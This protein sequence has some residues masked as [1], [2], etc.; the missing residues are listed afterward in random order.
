MK[1]GLIILIIFIILGVFLF[2]FR[3]I[4]PREIDDVTPAF[5]CAEELLEEADILFVI[6]KFNNTSL[7]E[8]PEW[9]EYILS[10]NKTLGLHGVYHTYREFLTDRNQTYL[11]EGINEFKACFGYEPEIFKPPQL[12]ISKNNRELIKQNNMILKTIPN[13]IIHK[14]YHC[15]Y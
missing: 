7:S 11:Q 2:C 6:P 5:F 15:P 3:L 13:K 4:S 12:K 9:C 14:I 8:N 1:K 10:L